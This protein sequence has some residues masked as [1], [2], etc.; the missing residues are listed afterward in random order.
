MQIEHLYLEMIEVLVTTVKF[1]RNSVLYSFIRFCCEKERVKTLSF[2]YW[3]VMM[4]VLKKE[5]SKLNNRRQ[6]LI[7]S[8][9]EQIK[10]L[11][12]REKNV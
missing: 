9:E 8:G 7:S 11:H 10:F 5:M 12:S 4:F 1:A 2:F 6:F 3:F